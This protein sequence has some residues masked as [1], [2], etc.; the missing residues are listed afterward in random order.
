MQL[1]LFSPKWNLNDEIGEDVTEETSSYNSTHTLALQAPEGSNN[2]MHPSSVRF[3]SPAP[4][5]GANRRGNSNELGE[6]E[7]PQQLEDDGLG[8]NEEKQQLGGAVTC[9]LADI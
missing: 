1:K 6:G 7:K 2:V 5:E 3:A 4:P 9:H 8:E